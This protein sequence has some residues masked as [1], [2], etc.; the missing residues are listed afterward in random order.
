MRAK[1]RF[2]VALVALFLLAMSGFASKGE[3]ADKVQAKTPSEPFHPIS[4][5]L[6]GPDSAYTPRLIGLLKNWTASVS[7]C[8]ADTEPLSITMIGIR[9]PNRPYYVG[10]KKCMLVSAPMKEVEAVID[11]S[12][13]FQNL[14][15]GLAGVKLVSKDGNKQV[16]EWERKIPVF[17]VPNLKYKIGYLADKTS[18]NRTVYRYQFISGDRIKFNDGIEVL[19]KL[20]DRL[21][22]FTNYEF[23][24]ADYGLGILGIRAVS[25]ESAWQESLKGGYLSVISIRLKA[26]HPDWTYDHVREAAEAEVKKVDMDKVTYLDSW[27]ETEDGTKSK[28]VSPKQEQK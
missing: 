26:E 4:E 6:G 23:Y 24:E 22:R 8:H 13:D 27:A 20:G 12:D 3:A 2:S 1:V 7:F 28:A 17:F 15:P 11:D 9:T 19:E 18:K 5:E 10:F 16:L 25:E 14:F 21:T